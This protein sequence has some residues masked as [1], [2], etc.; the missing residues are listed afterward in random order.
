MSKILGRGKIAL[1]LPNS[2]SLTYTSRI[3]SM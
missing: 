2:T 1:R 3:L